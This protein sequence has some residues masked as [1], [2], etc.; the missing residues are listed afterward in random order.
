MMGNK[1]DKLKKA[2][3]IVKAKLS[4]IKHFVIYF[5][6]VAVVAVLNNATGDHFQWW[7]WVAFGW[8]IA[9]VI[10]FLSVFLFQSRELENKMVKNELK[11]MG[12]K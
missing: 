6:V 9:V 12:D 4:F 10:H 8:G 1:E 7:L 5:I 2:R 3:E 11:K